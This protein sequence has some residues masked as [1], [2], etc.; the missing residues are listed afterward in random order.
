MRDRPL[1]HASIREILNYIRRKRIY[2]M[3]TAW[4][5]VYLLKKGNYSVKLLV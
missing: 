5:T 3:I 4:T 2:A 1:R